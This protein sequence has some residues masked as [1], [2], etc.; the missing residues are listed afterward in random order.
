MVKHI[1]TIRWFV[2]TICLSV[3]DHF[4]GLTLKAVNI[5]AANIFDGFLQTRKLKEKAFKSRNFE[6][7]YLIVRPNSADIVLST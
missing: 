5:S 7:V 6:K 2:S 3:F 4:V 1:Q